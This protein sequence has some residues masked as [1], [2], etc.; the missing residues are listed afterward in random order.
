MN[1]RQYDFNYHLAPKKGLLNDPNGL[2][3]FKGKYHVFYQW[4]QTGTVHKNKSWGHFVSDDFVTFTELAPALEPKDWFDKDGVYSGCAIVHE[5]KLYIFY[6]GNVK[7]AY[8]VRSAYQCLAT[9]DD[10]VNFEKKGPIF[11]Y[12]KGYTAHTRDPK[13]WYDEIE[14]RWLMVLGA[15]R[16]DLTGDTILY[17]SQNL[18]DWTFV[19]SVFQ[20]D[21][22]VGYMWEC[23]DLIQIDG[24]YVLICS[25]QGVEPDGYAYHNIYQTAYIIGEFK[26]NEFKTHATQF[27]EQ[28]R[29][30]EFYAPQTFYGTD[31]RV[32]QYGWMGIMEPNKEQAIPTVQD[33]WVHHLSLPRELRIQDN[34]LMQSPIK[35][36]EQLRQN[37]STFDV[38]HE[39][40]IILPEYAM[41]IVL[42][43][44]DDNVVRLQVR[45]EVVVFYEP[46]EKLVTVER[47]NWLTGEKEYRHC[48][49][50]NAL[51]NMRLLMEESSIELFIN[52]GEEVFSMRYFATDNDMTFIISGNA[53]VE[54]YEMKNMF[55]Q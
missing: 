32:I 48:V 3:K 18:L 37:G 7:D 53:T 1:R 2:V 50:R 17:Q 21:T 23:P 26:H 31:N 13:V 30:F 54:M 28:D 34:Y 24:R 43:G 6:T 46:I 44:L 45:N 16:E 29:G 40:I 52:N 27:I 35:E 10:G 20:F 9:S 41:D 25:P 22:P 4:N 5:D 38:T 33:G 42:Y 8:G 11:T 49:L 39:K 36:L 14:K 55:K 12:P 15:Q 19:G 47:T 51:D